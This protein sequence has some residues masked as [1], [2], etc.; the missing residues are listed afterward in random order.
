M[1]YL[2]NTAEYQMKILRTMQ[3]F[4]QPGQ[5]PTYCQCFIRLE[6]YPED[7]RLATHIVPILA[8]KLTGSYPTLCGP[9][10]ATYPK[11]TFPAISNTIQWFP[12]KQQIKYR[13]VA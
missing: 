2:I 9:L 10:L 13:I 8:S 5:L 3:R 6:S 7:S 1:R 11:S 4:E 12:L